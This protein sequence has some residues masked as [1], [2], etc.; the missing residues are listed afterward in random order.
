MGTAQAVSSSI[1]VLPSP[2]AAAHNSHDKAHHD[3]S[4]ALHDQNSSFECLRFCIENLPDHY[5]ATASTESPA[6]KVVASEPTKFVSA[7]FAIEY[8]I[9]DIINTARGPPDY[10]VTRAVTGLRGLLLLNARLRN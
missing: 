4:Q 10:W 2:P 1:L 7:D 8:Y 5:L 9:A 3:H 6:P